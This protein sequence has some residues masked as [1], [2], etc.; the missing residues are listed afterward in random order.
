MEW[1]RR[2]RERGG[3]KRLASAFWKPGS[4]SPFLVFSP[5][6]SF[7]PPFLSVEDRKRGRNNS[8]LPMPPSPALSPPVGVEFFLSPPP[9]LSLS[10][11]TKVVLWIPAE[12]EKGEGAKKGEERGEEG[13]REKSRVSGRLSCDQE[14]VGEGEREEKRGAEA[15]FLQPYLLSSRGL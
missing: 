6:P 11:P 1:Q 14:N 5:P 4:T 9:S 15:Y 13:E 3:G 12:E 7:S 10:L 8:P 2:P